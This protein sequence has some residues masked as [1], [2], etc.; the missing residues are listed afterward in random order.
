VSDRGTA[1]VPDEAAETDAPRSPA[2]EPQRLREHQGNGSH[3]IH[4]LDIPAV[5]AAARELSD[6][7]AEARAT[8]RPIREGERGRE[9]LDRDALH[10]RTLA[11]ADMAAAVAAAAAAIY[12]GGGTPT[13]AVVA[14]MPLVV[15]V[16]KVVGLYDRDEH[17]LHKTTLDEAPGLVQVSMAC[18]LLVWLLD[19]EFSTR[20]VGK[21]QVLLAWILLFLAMAVAR[22]VARR[23][24]LSVAAIER[25]LV[26]GSAR[27]ARRIEEKLATMGPLKAEVVG[28]VAVEHEPRAERGQDVLGIL[29]ELD[30]VLRLHRIDRVVIWPHGETSSAMLDT[31]RLAKGLGVKVSVV[32]RL[33]EVVGTSVEFDD[34]GGLTLLGLRR[35]D[36][37]KSSAFLKRALDVTG[38]T[39]GLVV[40]APLVASIALA[41]KLTSPG[42]V[43][44]RQGR[45]GR[46][47]G[48]FDMLK[49]RTMYD[50]ADGHKERLREHNE[51]E[52]FFKI[53]DDPRVTPVGRLL[54][55]T[56]LDE[57][58][59]LVN[60]LRGEMSLVGP[61][62]L[63]SEEDARIEGFSRRR[64]DVTPGMTG[65]WQVLGSSR[66]P[67]RDMVTIDYLYRANWSLWLD[68]KIL[69]R[70]IP[71]VLR[72]RGL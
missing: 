9:A 34:L 7:D 17:I 6:I 14:I 57:L 62:P 16:S 60:V 33:F 29:P 30:Y 4:A 23:A 37:T 50:G 20:A 42:P 26:L 21:P 55:R 71:H 10:R 18:T 28:R 59:Q 68:L 25:I 48:A 72:G 64:L 24:A 45:V 66:I 40:F 46:G 41:V 3:T 65:A 47:G 8:S 63:V 27:E 43:L 56:S 36:L 61:R 13:F 11:V 5:K 53:A 67:M 1:R 54:R 51:A 44:F 39:C 31:I 58:P 12:A 49:F 52:G 69:L 19:G 15:L 22:S 70:T 32:P 38:A 35:Y 2:D